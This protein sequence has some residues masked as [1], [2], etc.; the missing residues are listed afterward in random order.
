MDGNKCIL[1]L[2]GVRPF[3]SDKYDITKHPNF[4]YTADADDKNAFDI[5]A[6]LS[7][8]L[9]LKPNEV[10]DV[11]EVD[12]KRAL[13]FVPLLKGVILSIRR[14]CPLRAIGVQSGQ[15]QEKIM[16][17]ENSRNHAPGNRADSFFPAFVCL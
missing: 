7:A 6:F 14:T 2:R 16:K 9:K 11:Y 8:R 12:T 10:C 3:L 13:N 15:S 17:R 4:K 5:E 1:Q